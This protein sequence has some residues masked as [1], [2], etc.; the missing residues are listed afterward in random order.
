MEINVDQGELEKLLRSKSGP[1]GRDTVRRGRAVERGAKRRAPAAVKKGINAKPIA[2]DAQGLYVDI[3]S[4]AT[5]KDGAPLGLFTEVG[6][7]PHVIESHGDYPLRN[8]AGK[9]FGK[10]VNHP[11]TTEHPHLRPALAEDIDL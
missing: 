6:T 7:K 1:V 2:S 10:K 3:A 9:V 8:K 5:S 11:G 4:E